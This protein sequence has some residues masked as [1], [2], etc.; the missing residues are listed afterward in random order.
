MGFIFGEHSAGFGSA[1]GGWVEEYGFFDLGE[2]GAQ[3]AH[4]HWCSGVCCFALDESGD[5]EGEHAVKDVDADLLVG[6][7][8]HRAERHDP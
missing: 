8:E 2:G 4:A 1:S 3:F 6:P 7:V 5:G